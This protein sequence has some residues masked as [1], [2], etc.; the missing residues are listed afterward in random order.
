MNLENIILKNFIELSDDEKKMVLTWRNHSN[1]R[2]WMY[3]Q[4]EISL[5]NHLNFIESLKTR[6]DKLYFVVE[7]DEKYIGVIYFY[8]FENGSCEFGLYSNPALSAVGKILI[9]EIVNYAFNR[10]NSNL[11]IA[12]VLA[13]NERAINLY[14]KYNFKETKRKV[15]LGK[16]VIC[17]ELKK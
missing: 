8:N 12:E 11:L 14:K 5:E 6:D 1:I 10:L 17:M 15:V 13:N 16:E 9:N 4:D 7:K 3:T 2:K